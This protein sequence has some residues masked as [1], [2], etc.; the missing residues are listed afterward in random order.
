M[1]LSI[2][3]RPAV[4]ANH[5]QPA[6]GHPRFV[7]K[8]RH[9]DITTLGDVQRDA[10]V[11]RIIELPR[12]VANQTENDPCQRKKQEARRL[13]RT[14]LTRWAHLSGVHWLG[15]VRPGCAHGVKNGGKCSTVITRQ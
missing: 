13:E 3:E 1:L 5:A 9:D 2:E 15:D 6:I 12:I 7:S 10:E 11:G 8:I 14:I 4:V